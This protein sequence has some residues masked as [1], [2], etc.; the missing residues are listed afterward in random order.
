MSTRTE[1]TEMGDYRVVEVSKGHSRRWDRR[2]GLTST[3]ARTDPNRMAWLNYRGQG[4][5]DQL[6]HDLGGFYGF[7]SGEAAFLG[8]V[9]D[10]LGFCEGAGF[11]H[12]RD[13]LSHGGFRL[14][15]R[16]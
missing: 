5:F 7:Y 4:G 2:G 8:Y 15:V 13:L 16:G 3:K 9:V 11:G 6:Q 14:E 1:R 10:N 12:G